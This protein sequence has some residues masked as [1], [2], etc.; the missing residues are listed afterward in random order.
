MRIIDVIDGPADLDTLAAQDAL[1][2]TAYTQ[3]CLFVTSHAGAA[4][5]RER[6]LGFEYF[7]KY[8]DFRDVSKNNQTTKRLA[9]GWMRDAEAQSIFPWL[10]DFHGVPVGYCLEMVFSH[11]ICGAESALRISRR[12]LQAEQPSLVRF[13]P[14]AQP[15]GD[16]WCGIFVNP[17]RRALEAAARQMGIEVQVFGPP[18]AP[19]AGQKPPLTWTP[20]VPDAS[21]GGEER[22][23]E[24]AERVLFFGQGR[25]AELLGSMFRFAQQEHPDL[26]LYATMDM[27]DSVRERLLA[28]GSAVFDPYVCLE[29]GAAQE[30]AGVVETARNT[31]ERF[32]QRLA[33]FFASVGD[34]GEALWPLVRFQYDWFL[35]QGLPQVLGRVL[36]A[37]HALRRV[38]TRLVLTMA[39]STIFDNCWIYS[40]RSLG[41]PAMCILHGTLYQQPDPDYWAD[42]H[43]DICTVWGPLTQRWHTTSTGSPE[44]R[45]PMAGHPQFDD[46]LE[47]FAAAETAQHAARLKLDPERP[48]I[49][50]LLSMMGG[51]MDQMI[52][53]PDM[54]LEALYKGFEDVPGCQVLIRAHPVTNMEPVHAVA[55]RHGVT[56][57]IGSEMEV[58]PFLKLCDVVLSQPT[59]V[60]H[61][62]MLVGIPVIVCAVQLSE[63]L[64]W[65]RS[66]ADILT[67]DD[68]AD[69]PGM[70]ASLL[71]GGDMREAVLARQREFTEQMLGPLDGKACERILDVAKDAALPR[72]GARPLATAA[73]SADLSQRPG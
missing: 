42:G 57:V 27:N 47:R 58:M 71:P 66:V 51:G 23:D 14:A 37:L 53:H 17:T 18:Q 35:D 32:Y 9:T 1:A 56:T 63:M 61:E 29:P 21:L 70:V 28:L 26:M 59:T 12:L 49:G 67:L 41:I 64:Q 39:D 4:A 6:G 38:R 68:P 72:S 69:L 10:R 33:Q 36:T 15:E 45:F 8:K 54:L 30:V 65:W 43:S 25:H 48:V 50:L 73:S 31:R 60:V 34:M 62:A 24:L 22:L 2:G 7:E 16:F 40:A 11:V 44:Q 19:K 3:R 55:A 46:L 5:C 13:G 20:P 52:T